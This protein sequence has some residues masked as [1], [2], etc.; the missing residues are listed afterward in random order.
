VEGTKRS[1]KKN[2]KRK[3]LKSS[4]SWNEFSTSLA[5]GILQ[6][7]HFSF[8]SASTHLSKFHTSNMHTFS[9]PMT[10]RSIS[11]DNYYALLLVLLFLLILVNMGICLHTCLTPQWLTVT[12]CLLLPKLYNLPCFVFCF[13]A[14]VC[15][16]LLLGSSCFT[17]GLWAID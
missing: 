17:I 6:L 13:S 4:S 11:F 3:Q 16:I 14:C 1:N 10:I 7:D 2:I 12:E 8:L 9:C 15:I 5:E